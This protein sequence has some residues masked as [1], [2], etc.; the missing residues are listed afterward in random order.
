MSNPVFDGNGEVAGQV[1]DLDHRTV[2][3]LFD[4]V[5]AWQGSNMFAGMTGHEAADWIGTA[6]A[7][8]AAGRPVAPGEAG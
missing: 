3:V 2:E 1:E 8:T 6:L 4:T 5:E 7:S